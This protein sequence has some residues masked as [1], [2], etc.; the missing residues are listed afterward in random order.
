MDAMKEPL[1][2]S[3]ERADNSVLKGEGGQKHS[4]VGEDPGSLCAGGEEVQGA[5]GR[6]EPPEA[7]TM[8]AN[9]VLKQL[10]AQ[11]SVCL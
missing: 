8:S 3:R 10:E 2:A 4:V 5:G 6:S 9:D 11:V 7:T 1:E